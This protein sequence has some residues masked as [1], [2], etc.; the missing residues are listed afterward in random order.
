MLLDEDQNAYLADF[1]IAKNLGN[2]NLADQTNVE[3]IIGSPAYLS[4]EQ[5]RSLSVRPQTD[6]YALGV[7]L[8]ELLTGS[9]PFAG[10]TPF[11]LIQQHIGAPMPP[12][13]ARR[14]GLPAALDVVI[15]RAAAKEPQ[16]RYADVLTLLDDFR[17]AAQGVLTQPIALPISEEEEAIELVNP[18]K[19]LRAFGEADVDDYF[20]REGLIQQLLA[21]LGE[22][23]DL[24]RFLA[25]VGPSGSGKSSVV[26]AGLVPALRRGALVGSE[27]WYIVDFLPGAHPFEEL[28]AALLRVAVNPPESLLSQLKDGER[29]LTR[30]VRRVL[31][32]D[33]AIELVIVIDQ[34]EEVFTLLN[35]EAE[36]ALFLNSL[37][38][39]VLDERSRV[40]VI[41]TLRADFVDRPLRYTDFGELLQR[42]SEFVLP[43]T[44]DEVERAIVGPARRIGLRLESGLVSTMIR[45]VSDQ[46][47]A[48]PLMEYALTEL[49]EKRAGHTLTKAAYES[50]GGVLGALG[51]RAEEVYR[52]LSEPEQLIARQILLRLVTFGEGVEDTRRR[53]LRSEIESLSTKNTKEHEE[54]LSDLR[55]LRGSEEIDTILDVYGKHRLLTFD[56]DP[57]TREHVGCIDAGRAQLSRGQCRR[58]RSPAGRRSR[59]AAARTGSR[60]P[61][62]GLRQFFDPTVKD[63]SLANRRLRDQRA[64]WHFDPRTSEIGFFLHGYP[65]SL[66]DSGG[67]ALLKKY[68]RR[69]F[70]LG[71]YAE[72]WESAI[73]SIV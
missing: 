15:A 42:R 44:P 6:I 19:G 25:V 12:L 39:A 64:S 49:F 59:S 58:K 23:G 51:R 18:Y 48:L 52:A 53:V 54:K 56:H 66:T 33:E 71:T 65:A 41:M 68:H 35:D 30:A 26:G 46:P 57:I 2:P 45:E 4:P 36:R 11:D 16:D 20:G 1:G 3:M 62:F 60:A 17:R 67:R 37:V 28:E 47:G 7:M 55:A 27:N 63:D 32:A 61:M 8:Y 21:R 14:E 31:P 29:G 38:T 5:I 22:G 10:P 9:V 72:R 43:L 70:I 69:G 34:F 24:A 13:A 40:R 73:M 50:I